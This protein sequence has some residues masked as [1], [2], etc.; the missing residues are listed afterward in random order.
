M[1]ELTTRQACRVILYATADGKVKM[2]DSVVSV[3]ETTAADGKACVTRFC[4]EY[5]QRLSSLKSD[6]VRW[7]SGQSKNSGTVSRKSGG[8]DAER[9]I[10]KFRIVA[11]GAA[12]GLKGYSSCW[13]RP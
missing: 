10:R 12:L 9:T 4:L 3:L 1:S 8:T 5:S 13:I 11:T 7:K 2:V 6:A